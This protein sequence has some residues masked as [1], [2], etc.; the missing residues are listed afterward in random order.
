MG[1]FLTTIKDNILVWPFESLAKRLKPKSKSQ[2]QVKLVQI[3][4]T[5]G[6]S[7]KPVVLI[8]LPLSLTIIAYSSVSQPFL[9]R[10]TFP[11]LKNNLEAPLTTIYQ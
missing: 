1:T 2:V 9:I 11:L 7:K 6:T 3:R 5:L 8:L 10:G 4:D